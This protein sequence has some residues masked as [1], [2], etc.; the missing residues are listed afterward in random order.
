MRLYTAILSL[1][2]FCSSAFGM[3][4]SEHRLASQ[5]GAEILKAGG[6]A[7][8][9]AV[10]V[11]Y[12]LAVVNACCGNIGGG[13]FMLI[14]L[15]TGKDIAINFRETAPQ[16]AT[17]QMFTKLTHANATTTGYAAVA[18]PG[19]VMGL[20]TA[21]K[22]YGTL[23]RAKVMAPA[24]RLAEQGYLI[25]PYEAKQFQEYAPDFRAQP[26]VA[27]IFLP[28]GKPLLAGQRLIQSDL[29]NT[30]KLIA[31]QGATAFYD[32]PIANAIVH[33]SHQHGGI[34]SE[35]DFHDYHAIITQPTRCHYH[36]MTILTGPTGSGGPVL[37]NMLTAL[38]TKTLRPATRLSAN[39]IDI[40]V[41]TMRDGFNKRNSS[42]KYPSRVFHRELTDT[43]HY[44]IVDDQGNAVAVTY[45]INGFF[46]ARVIAGNTGFFLNNEMDDFT[47]RP[48]IPNKFGLVQSEA[49][50][51]APGK[52]PLSSMTPT[53]VFDHQQLM[54]VLGSPGGPRIITS[55]LL[56]LLNVLDYGMSLQAAVDAPRFHYQ[57][58]PDYLDVEPMTLSLPTTIALKRLGYSIR[59]QHPWSAVEAIQ[60]KQGHIIGAND[61]RRPDGA[62]L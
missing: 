2:V 15:A 56:T 7:V 45:T 25:S 28:A 50:A 10:A 42:S 29:A 55:V 52:R 17:K 38:N 46:G 16:H 61:F 33:A 8:D 6:N 19:T 23:S 35:S 40:I 51:I 36:H 39:D 34:L 24:I 26:N 14:H 53:M 5:A 20:D 54:L 60:L 4:V 32:G 31:K 30:L 9:A 49:N 22:R 27:A 18:T 57:V 21:L 43:T 48:G 59:E 11:G 62:A 41:K 3:V 13:G 44:S 47:T 58:L 37:C 12:A 1:L